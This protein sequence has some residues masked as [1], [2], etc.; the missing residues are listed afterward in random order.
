[1]SDLEVRTRVDELLAGVTVFTVDEDAVAARIEELPFVNEA[2]VIRH[3]P[4][5]L[6]LHVLSSTGHWHWATATVV[7]GSCHTTDAS[8]R[9]P[10]AKSGRGRSP[11]SRSMAV[12]LK[13][14]KRVDDEPSL[15]LL[16]AV[17]ASSSLAFDLIEADSF[18]LTARLVGGV[19]VR[20]GLSRTD[21]AEGARAR[22]G[23]ARRRPT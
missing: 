19:E 7:S 4:G 9:R 22:E 14:G 10:E 6:E 12:K 15:R 1:M 5:G 8:S 16:G 2:S 23:V 21:A 3:L 13:A 20:F 17:P 18:Q 11:P